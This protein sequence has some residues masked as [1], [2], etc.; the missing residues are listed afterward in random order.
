MSGLRKKGF[1]L[2]VFDEKEDVN[3]DDVEVVFKGSGVIRSVFA[4]SG[5][6][7]IIII[8][9]KYVIL[10]ESAACCSV[11]A[12][13]SNWRKILVEEVV[14]SRACDYSQVTV[15]VQKKPG[16]GDTTL[17]IYFKDVAGCDEAKEEIVEFVH[18]PKN[19]KKY[20]DLE[21]KFQKSG[22]R[23]REAEEGTMATIRRHFYRWLLEFVWLR[24]D[25]SFVFDWATGG[26]D[27]IKVSNSALVSAF[28]TELECDY[29]MLQLS[30]GPFLERNEEFL[31][32]CMDDLSMK[33]Q[34]FQ[35]Y[36]RNLSRQQAHQ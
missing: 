27:Q 11:I 29:E 20:E 18:F 4:F 21:P 15:T 16:R 2:P 32:E 9:A 7:R 33:Q 22:D 30:T 17:S 31:I 24:T 5:G 35:Y 1:K 13:L 36:Y 23:E 10:L 6:G 28:M 3:M 8:L 14:R 34:K 19:P 25:L 26:C 12:R